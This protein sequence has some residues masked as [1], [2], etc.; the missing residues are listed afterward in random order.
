[1]N[2]KA[3][4]GEVSKAVGEALSLRPSQLDDIDCEEWT[5]EMLAEDA[6]HVHQTINSVCEQYGWTPSEFHAIELRLPNNRHFR[7]DY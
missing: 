2:R 4:F 5:K 7:L 3:L 1:M 6:A